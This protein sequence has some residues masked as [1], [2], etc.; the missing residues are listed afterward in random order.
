MSDRGG[1]TGAWLEIGGV[2]VGRRAPLVG[3]P[4]WH[5]MACGF[6]LLCPSSVAI[7]CGWSGVPLYMYIQDH[8]RFGMRYVQR[9]V[10]AVGS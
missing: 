7:G 2:G 3:V 4:S 8:D 6:R 9:H 10:P 1:R 5:A